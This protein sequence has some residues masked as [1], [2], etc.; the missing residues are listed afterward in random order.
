MVSDSFKGNVTVYVAD[1][2]G[3]TV[4]NEQYNLASDNMIQLDAN[5]FSPGLYFVNILGQ[6]GARAVKKLIVR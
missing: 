3:R 1:I 2:A 4:V 5:L 6:D